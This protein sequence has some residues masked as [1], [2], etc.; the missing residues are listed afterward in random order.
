MFVSCHN[1][2]LREAT[3]YPDKFPTELTPTPLV[4]AHIMRV[5]VVGAGTEYVCAWIRGTGYAPHETPPVW[6]GRVLGASGQR[7]SAY[8]LTTASRLETV[9]VSSSIALRHY[10]SLVALIE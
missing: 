1:L 3:R 7:H 4:Y 2:V 5:F 8:A 6:S 9:F 10:S